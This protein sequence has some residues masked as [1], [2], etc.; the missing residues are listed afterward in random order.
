MTNKEG[1]KGGEVPSKGDRLLDDNK[2]K[3]RRG[4]GLGT[5]KPL[6]EQIEKTDLS[7]AVIEELMEDWQECYS[8]EKDAKRPEFLDKDEVLK[9][10]ENL[11]K[12]IEEMIKEKQEERAEV[13]AKKNWNR[14]DELDH[15][16]LDVYERALVDVLKLLRGDD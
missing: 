14:E 9:S 7:W 15:L 11:I 4:S 2:P 5:L 16:Y 13:Q 6:K 12:Q 3:K 1:R 10:I 8:Y